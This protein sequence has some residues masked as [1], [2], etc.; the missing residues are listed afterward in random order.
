M[1]DELSCGCREYTRR[2]MLIDGLRGAGA[3]FLM[4]S[5]WQMIATELSA[6]ERREKILVVVELSGGND[7][8]NTVIPYTDD[9]YYNHRPTLGIGAEKVRKLSDHVG[10]HPAMDAFERLYKDGRL[11]IVQ[12]CSYP[13][14]NRS[15]F[16]AMEF[17]HTG[18]PNGTDANG[19]LGRWAD[20]VYAS[21]RESLIVNIDTRE[22]MAVRSA[23]HSSIVFDNPSQYMRRDGERLDPALHA[24][25][26]SAAKKNETLARLREMSNVADRSSAFVRETCSRYRTPVEYGRG[27]R[28]GDD[29]KKVAALIAASMPARIYY[30]SY[31]GFDTHAAQGGEEGNQARLLRQVTDAVESFHKDIERMGRA[32]EVAILV[33]TEFGRRVKENASRGTDHGVATPVFVVGS[34]VKGGLYGEHPSLSDLDNGD[35]KMTTDYRRVYASLLRE[36]L[37]LTDVKKVLR[38]EFGGLGVLA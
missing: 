1:N 32:G 24:M 28:L 22:A 16:E 15:H 11:A 6:Q 37:G 12:G 18:I 25:E 38:E 27:N 10:L 3:M 31:G 36:W 2:Q 30:T 20:A 26:I 5:I 13:N 34:N 35:L 33:F 29:L 23:V 9:L 8:L 21:P 14:P 4:P 19:W 7:G 17:W